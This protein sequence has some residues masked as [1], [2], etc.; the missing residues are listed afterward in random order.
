MAGMNG[1][2]HSCN[3]PKVKYEDYKGSLKA[4]SYDDADISLIWDFYVTYAFAAESAQSISLKDYGW[5]NPEK[6]LEKSLMEK[7]QIDKLCCIRANRIY[8]TLAACDMSNK[9]ICITHSRGVVQQK[10]SITVDENEKMSFAGGSGAE[11]R[12]TCLFRHIRNAL[13]HGGTYF[14][15]S[16]N[17]LL[18]DKDNSK[19][20]ARKIIPQQ[21]LL[22][23]I[24]IVDKTKILSNRRKS[25]VPPNFR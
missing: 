8:D 13:A 14:F 20:T 17:M 24:R 2:T 11:T 12:I 19:I 5:E 4:S 22:D 18:E 1:F 3:C 16:G 21:A 10:Y 25:H 9:E 6:D 15:E 23:W 7:A